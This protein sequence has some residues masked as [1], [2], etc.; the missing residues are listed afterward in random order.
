MQ[1][2]LYYYSG[3]N[4]KSG[5]APTCEFGGRCRNYGQSKT[6]PGKNIGYLGVLE[7][8]RV[9][10]GE[11][12]ARVVQA[13]EQKRNCPNAGRVKSM[14]TVKRF[15]ASKAMSLMWVILRQS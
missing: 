6:M 5:M 4:S 12:A 7:C 3:S 15:S 8:R 14:R 13:D 11:P 9:R 2:I 10:A 1:A